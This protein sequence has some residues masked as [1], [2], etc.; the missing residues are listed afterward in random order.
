MTD[1]IDFQTLTQCTPRI[2]PTL[3]TVMY[4]HMVYNCFHTLLNLVS[5]LWLRIFVSN[6]MRDIAL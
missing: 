2:N 4:K 5:K 3:Y 1:F 6:F